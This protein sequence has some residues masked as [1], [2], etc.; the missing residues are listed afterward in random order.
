MEKILKTCIKKIQKYTPD[1]TKPTREQQM[2]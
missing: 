2:K 1:D